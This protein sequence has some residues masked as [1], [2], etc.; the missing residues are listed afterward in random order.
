[1]ATMAGLVLNCANSALYMANYN[2]VV[3][4]C[5]R[6]RR[7]PIVHLSETLR[8]KPAWS[9]G[10][11]PRLLPECSYYRRMHPV[12]GLFLTIRSLC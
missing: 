8:A 12:T 10:R 11:V 3:R 6:F 4:C 5:S 7:H 2:L 1:M 9:S